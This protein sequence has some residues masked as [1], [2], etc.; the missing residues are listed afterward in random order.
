MNRKLK[1]WIRR[2]TVETPFDLARHLNRFVESYNATPHE[3]LRNMCPNDV[4]A[5]RMNDILSRRARMKWKTMLRR[6][7]VNLAGAA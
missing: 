4:Y 1:A 6:R 5:G 7:R 2:E 3:S